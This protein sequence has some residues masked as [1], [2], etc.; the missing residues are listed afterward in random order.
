MHCKHCHKGVHLSGIEDTPY[1]HD[2]GFIHCGLPDM[3]LPQ[4]ATLDIEEVL[5]ALHP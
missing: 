1:V 4:E 2:S 5:D 3:Y